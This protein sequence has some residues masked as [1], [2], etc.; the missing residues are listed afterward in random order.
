VTGDA[1]GGGRSAF[2]VLMTLG[3]CTQR[4][5]IEGREAPRGENR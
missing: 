2:I 5:P 3:N 4:D 1:A